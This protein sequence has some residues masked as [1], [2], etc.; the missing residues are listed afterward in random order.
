MYVGMNVYVC[1]CMYVRVYACMH[2]K[3][4]GYI[5][6]MQIQTCVRYTATAKVIQT[7]IDLIN[8]VSLFLQLAWKAFLY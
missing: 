3:M 2:A 6:D 1:V 5:S 8:V 7:T 4:Y